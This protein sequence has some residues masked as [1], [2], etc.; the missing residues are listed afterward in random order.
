M[1]EQDSTINEDTSVFK[2]Y[3]LGVQ[4]IE[5]HSPET[6]DFQYQFEAPDHVGMTFVDP[7]M[8][9]LYADI[10]FAVNGFVEDDTGG[11]GIP[12]EVVQAGKHA[13]A[14]YLLVQTSMDWVCSFYGTEPVRIDNFVAQVRKQ[15][16]EMRA[17]AE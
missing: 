13:L 17:R 1:P 7:E 2:E 15:A 12:P 3:P 16:E 14:A 11:R 8:A 4:I 9:T 10:F 5:N 6:S